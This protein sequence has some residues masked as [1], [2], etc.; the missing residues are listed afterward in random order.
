MTNFEKCQSFPFALATLLLLCAS[1]FVCFSFPAPQTSVLVPPQ[2]SSIKKI[3]AVLGKDNETI[4][5]ISP[6]WCTKLWVDNNLEC[7]IDAHC[8]PATTKGPNGEDGACSCELADTSLVDFYD[9]VLPNSTTLVLS[10]CV[11]AT[12]TDA[13]LACYLAIAIGALAVGFR[14]ILVIR[15][16]RHYKIFRLDVLGISTCLLLI[17]AICFSLTRFNRALL[18]STLLHSNRALNN[19]DNQVHI[20][21][22]AL[23]V[24]FVIVSTLF[25][26]VS[27]IRTLSYASRAMGVLASSTGPVST[28]R[29]IGIAVGIFISLGILLSSV[30]GQYQVTSLVVAVGC[31]LVFSSYGQLARSLTKTMKYQP[32]KQSHEEIRVPALRI[33]SNLSNRLRLHLVIL[34]IVAILYAAF[35]SIGRNSQIRDYLRYGTG[36]TAV[37]EYLEVLILGIIILFSIEDLWSSKAPRESRGVLSN[38]HP[39]TLE[40]GISTVTIA[41]QRT[42]FVPDAVQRATSAVELHKSASPPKIN[43]HK[44]VSHAEIS[45]H[46]KSTSPPRL[47]H[48][49]IPEDTALGRAR[50]TPRLLFGNSLPVHTTRAESVSS[51]VSS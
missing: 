28:A 29:R 37:I 4:P 14:L 39:H 5:T 15:E 35:W 23:M 44:F 32:S 31:I 3:V 18:M 26:A 49:A 33:I 10:K 51:L 42:A 45:R 40:H 50:T 34:V 43:A 8:I 6:L 20:L 9:F 36:I 38:Q 30:F 11:R 1:V 13:F 27:V 7:P 12:F 46:K 47:T 2:R 48:D 41:G 22:S 21:I 17:A 19:L 24:F 25:F 16:A